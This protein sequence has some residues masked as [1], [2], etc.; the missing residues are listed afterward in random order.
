MS[1]SSEMSS[2][3]NHVFV[4][5]TARFLSNYNASTTGLMT[6]RVYE[7]FAIDAA[8]KILSPPPREYD[9]TLEPHTEPASP[10]YQLANTLKNEDLQNQKILEKSP[11]ITTR[12][13]LITK[14]NER[15]QY[16]FTTAYP[17]FP[18]RILNIELKSITYEMPVP[19]ISSKQINFISYD[20]NVCVVF[21]EYMNGMTL[22]ETKNK[23]RKEAQSKKVSELPL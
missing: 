18:P 23:I 6:E 13:E 21:D 2:R 4:S 19:V 5:F 22:E 14:I 3:Y 15:A 11:Q 1:S 9:K 10:N 7:H 20:R 12:D 17:T 16:Q 8:L